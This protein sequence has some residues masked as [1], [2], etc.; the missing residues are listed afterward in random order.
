MF[1]AGIRQRTCGTHPDFGVG[2]IAILVQ[3]IYI[4][5]LLI[6]AESWERNSAALRQ[7]LV[8]SG[9]LIASISN[10]EHKLFAVIAQLMD[11]QAG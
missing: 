2:H 3:Y 6:I 5:I 4:P 1:D 10:M 8:D 7:I 9:F 11:I